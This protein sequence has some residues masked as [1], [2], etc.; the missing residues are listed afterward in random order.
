MVGRIESAGTP[1]YFRK[2]RSTKSPPSSSAKRARY[3]CRAGSFTSSRIREVE[4]GDP[5]MMWATMS[6]ITRIHTRFT[7]CSKPSETVRTLL[8]S[9]ALKFTKVWDPPPVRNR[10]LG[11]AEYLR[12]MAA[13]SIP[14]RSVSGFSRRKPTAQRAR[15]SRGGTESRRR[16]SAGRGASLLEE[17]LHHLQ[18]GDERPELR[19]GAQLDTAALVDVEG[20]V[21]VVC[22]DPDA[23]PQGCPLAQGEG[24]ED[25]GRVATFQQPEGGHPRLPHVGR[26]PESPEEVGGHLLLR[27]VD[28]RFDSQ[29]HPVQLI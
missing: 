9:V 26:V 8:L 18:V 19:R 2:N 14:G 7:E 28:G 6:R 24:V 27:Q 15:L 22:L 17:L 23:V 20:S 13:R 21:E 3:S 5:Y 10:S 16:E 25:P 1:E 11:L 4:L 29:V 12:S